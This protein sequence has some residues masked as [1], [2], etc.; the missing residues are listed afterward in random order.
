VEEASVAEAYGIKVGDQ[1]LEVNGVSFLNI[2]HADAA[3]ALRAQPCMVIKVK[4]VGK[5]P[6]SRITTYGQTHWHQS[7]G[8]QRYTIVHIIQCCTIIFLY[9]SQGNKKRST[10]KGLP[11]GSW[12]T[13]DAPQA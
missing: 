5:L 8:K 7:Q 4:D 13:S 1:I 2:V 11:E 6:H 9:F 12:H 3:R 10:I